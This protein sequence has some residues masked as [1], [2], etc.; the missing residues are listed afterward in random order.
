[1]PLV[2]R[3]VPV[4]VKD[5]HDGVGLLSEDA[6]GLLCDASEDALDARDA[7]AIDDVGREAEGDEFGDGEEAALQNEKKRRK[8][9]VSFAPNRSLLLRP[10]PPLSSPSP[11]PSQKEAFGTTHRLKRD[12]KINMHQFARVL[13]EQDVA[14]MAIPES[15]DVSDDAR[16]GDR[17]RV[18][19]SHCEPGHGVLVALGEVVAEDGVELL[20]ERDEFGAHLVG[21]PSV[22][23]VGE[24][25]HAGDKVGGG[26]VFGVVSEGRVGGLGKGRISFSLAKDGNE[27]ESPISPTHL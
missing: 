5:S 18:V 24:G 17:P 27:N 12:P 1:M 19:K 23:S 22:R 11:P 7:E 14:E 20:L 25:L 3:I 8:T 10:P 2:Q 15:H 21:R 9:R 16:D 4:D 6:K 26:D 13:I